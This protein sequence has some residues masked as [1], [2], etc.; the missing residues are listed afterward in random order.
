MA[1]RRL[2]EED[3]FLI[4]DEL[5]SKLP[6]A[7][8]DVRADRAD[9]K[10]T[11][12]PPQ[13]YFIFS[14]AKAYRTPAVFII[15]NRMDMRNDRQGA[16][17]INGL[18]SIT[19]SVVIEDRTAESLVIKAFRYQAAIHQV[20]HETVLTSTDNKVKIVSKVEAAEFS[21]EFTKADD[22]NIPEGI[23]RKEIALQLNVEHYENF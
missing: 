15:V 18:S 22:P 19:V 7:L 5:K 14:P 17:H 10:V 6:G 1:G 12:E 3:I 13:S 8:A 11:T 2:V 21:A 23:F 20:L 9:A 4:R 16:N